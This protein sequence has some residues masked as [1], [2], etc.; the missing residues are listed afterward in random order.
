[1]IEINFFYIQIT[2]NQNLEAYL[3]G[4]HVAHIHGNLLKP[5]WRIEVFKQK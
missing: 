4:F 2:Y 5:C 3:S 1:M